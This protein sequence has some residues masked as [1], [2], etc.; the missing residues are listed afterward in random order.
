MR[1]LVSTGSSL[2]H[3]SVS[4]KSVVLHRVCVP[5][6]EPFRISNGVVAHK[7]SILIEVTT[8]DGV[9]GWGECSPMTG[10]FYS[11]ITPEI[12]WQNLTEAL[13]PKVLNLR[14]FQPESFYQELRQ[15]PADNF[16]K[17]G[18]EGALW[19]VLAN[20][21]GK[22]LCELLGVTRRPVP[23]GVAIGIFDTVAEL[24]ERVRLYVA[25]GYQ[26]VKIKIQPGWDLEPV[27]MIRQHLPEVQLMVDANAAYTLS[28]SVMFKELD[29]FDLMMIE[30]P[31]AADAIDEAGEL[32]AQLKTPLCADES[33]ESL[34]TLD[35][36]IQK[37]AAQI[38]NIKVQRVGGLSEAL[39]MLETALNA[40]L[41]CWIG[42]M[43]ELGIASAQ[44][45]HLAMHSGFTFPT[46]I[47]A[48]TRW[49][50]NDVIEPYIEIDHAGFIHVPEG[51]GSGFNVSHAKVEQYT[52][53]V[54][55]F[56]H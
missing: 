32:Q 45:L 36:L 21:T 31:L 35:Q 13:I 7:D 30:Q 11:S 52:T 18:I 33:A 3:Q 44:A 15:M 43:P 24:L 28:D 6:A 37:K 19:E 5:L 22:S 51:V 54:A 17:T 56:E 2:V 20:R 49:Y 39:L 27:S 23:S 1:S 41:K 14:D 46:D 29:Q 9:K 34:T 12:S 47:E 55:R 50:V 4:V 38:I 48:S 26:R 25:Q 40:G 8:V 10:T 53:A 16:S 42:T